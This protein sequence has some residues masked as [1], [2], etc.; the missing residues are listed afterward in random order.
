MP[1]GNISYITKSTAHHSTR[2]FSAQQQDLSNW[3]SLAEYWYSR[4][5][6]AKRR[7]FGQ[8]DGQD[9]DTCRQQF[10]RVVAIGRNSP[11]QV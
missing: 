8:K 9:S 4:R 1:P 6:P 2:T 11:S 7:I 10:R 3:H 5:L